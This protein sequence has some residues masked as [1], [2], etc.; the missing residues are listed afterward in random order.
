MIKVEHQTF[1]DH[2]GSYTPIGLNNSEYN[3][4]QCSISVNEKRFTFRGLHYQS[5]YFQAKYIKVIQGSIIDF[6]VDLETKEVEHIRL[7]NQNGILI[8]NT[9][10][11]GFLTLEPNTII[12]YLVDNKYAPGY[13]HSIVW[14]T[15]PEVESVIKS[16]VGNNHIVISEK[17]TIG[18]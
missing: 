10:A 17:D 9:K 15:I 12:C 13:E 4:T 2:R 11:H 8:P 3:W 1:F 14:N 5:K 16:Y 6:V 7:D 18:K